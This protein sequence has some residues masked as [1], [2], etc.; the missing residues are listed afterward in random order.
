MNAHPAVP[1]RPFKLVVPRRVHRLRLPGWFH[2]GSAFPLPSVPTSPK[3]RPSRALK[4]VHFPPAELDPKTRAAMETAR[5]GDSPRWTRQPRSSLSIPILAAAIWRLEQHPEERLAV[6]GHA[7]PDGSTGANETLSRARA[8]A[9]KALLVG[10]R[11]AFL[12]AVGEDIASPDDHVVLRF[13][14]ER[15]GWGCDPGPNEPCAPPEGAVRAYQDAYNHTFDAS[16][17]VDGI[18]GPQTRATYWELYETQLCLY[19]G[20]QERLAALRGAIVWHPD[21][22][23]VLATSD[24]FPLEDVPGAGDPQRLSRRVE[25]LFLS[26]EDPSDTLETAAELGSMRVSMIDLDLAT[27]SGT[28]LE[29]A[30]EE[31]ALREKDKA[32]WTETTDTSRRKSVTTPRFTSDTS[33]PFHYLDALR[34]ARGGVANHERGRGGT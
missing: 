17:A 32:A 31:F 16:I 1:N 23:N 26:S 28:P 18:V 3:T 22:E 10:N 2:A 13:A 6:T 24:L 19:V 25:L 12:D 20:G 30:Q 21:H 9:V 34:M 14:Q 27:I 5:S 33:D 8:N 15:F 4:T 29:D 7:S 11:D